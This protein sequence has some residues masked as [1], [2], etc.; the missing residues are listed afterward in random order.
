VKIDELAVMVVVQIGILN[1]RPALAS[2]KQPF[3]N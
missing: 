2:S 3:V 1:C